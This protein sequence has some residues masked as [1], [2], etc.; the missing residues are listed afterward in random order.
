MD[1]LN[2]L[3]LKYERFA[4]LSCKDIEIGKFKFVA[5]TQD[6]CCLFANDF[7]DLNVSIF[8]L[9]AFS[10]SIFC[11]QYIVNYSTIHVTKPVSEKVI[12][13]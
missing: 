13:P 12:L 3:S 9:L 1:T 5:K 7:N 11:F 4:P 10:T 8:N 6:I 2:N